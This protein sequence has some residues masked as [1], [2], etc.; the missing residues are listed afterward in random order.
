[1]KSIREKANLLRILK[2]RYFLLG[3][4]P[5]IIFDTCFETFKLNF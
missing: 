4:R 3:G 5:D 2:S 1:M